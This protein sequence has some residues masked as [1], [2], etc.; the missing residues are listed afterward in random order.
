MKKFGVEGG[1][2]PEKS[3]R[4]LVRVPKTVHTVLE[5]E[6]KKEGVSL[7]Q[8]AVAKLAMPLRERMDLCIPLIV[9]AYTRVYD[10]Y[11]TDRVVVDPDL[12]ARFLMVCRKLGL[13]QS[14]YQLNHALMDIRKSKKAILPKATKR[15]EFRDYDTYQFASEIAVRI[16]QRT[17]GVSLDRVLCDPRT[18]IEFDAIAKRLAPGQS[19]LKLRCA[20]L[21]LR[22]THRLEAVKG[23]RVPEYHLVPAGSLQALVIPEVPSFPAAYALY[24][25]NR[26][27][28]AGE[29]EDLRKRVETHLKSG[30]PHWLGAEE[31]FDLVL[32]HS[33]EPAAKLEE[34]RLWLSDFINKEK[35]LLNYQ[36]VA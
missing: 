19:A 17:E 13:T 3:G 4:I 8:L 25:H 24:D 16:L 31:G 29:T 26:P 33:A 34:R 36:K 1:A 32:K 9:D 2:T 21:N 23:Q 28:F 11:S 22:K 35:P 12:N 20:A 18:A 6:A 14:D 15:T 27:I 7:N 10:G 30:L 5:I